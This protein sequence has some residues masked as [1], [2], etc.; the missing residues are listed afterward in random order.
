MATPAIETAASRPARR[1]VPR[2]K[3]C[4]PRRIVIATVAEASTAA[5]SRLTH[6]T[7]A[8][9]VRMKR[10]VASSSRGSSRRTPAIRSTA[11]TGATAAAAIV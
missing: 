6:S 7:H 10:S 4:C 3:S 1:P 8:V 2:S 9:R 5:S 11:Y